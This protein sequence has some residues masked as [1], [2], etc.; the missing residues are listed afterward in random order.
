M[1]CRAIWNPVIL[2][3][4]TGRMRQWNVNVEQPLTTLLNRIQSIW[5]TKRQNNLL[6]WEGS[7]HTMRITVSARDWVTGKL[8]SNFS[9]FLINVTACSRSAA[10][11]GG[12]VMGVQQGLSVLYQYGCQRVA[13]TA[14]A[15]A[16]AWLQLC[17]TQSRRRCTLSVPHK[18]WTL[19]IRS[20]CSL[21]GSHWC[22]FCWPFQNCY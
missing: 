12:R 4:G 6:A 15:S 2:L 3:S 19:V 13:A 9:Q 18:K 5:I 8:R 11:G 16:P 10:Q 14:S 1:V 7:L 17:R 22:P 20:R 21:A